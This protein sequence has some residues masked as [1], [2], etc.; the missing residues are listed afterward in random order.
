[1]LGWIS[2]AQTFKRAHIYTS[3]MVGVFHSSIW[4]LHPPPN[5]A[6]RCAFCRAAMNLSLGH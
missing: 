4:L 3:G 1:M 2:T 5:A 6:C